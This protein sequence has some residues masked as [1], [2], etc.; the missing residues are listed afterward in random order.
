MSAR[1]HDDDA[2]PSELARCSMQGAGKSIDSGD[3]DDMDDLGLV[4]EFHDIPT[5]SEH[6]EFICYFDVLL[7]VSEQLILSENW[8]EADGQLWEEADHRISIACQGS[9]LVAYG[10][11]ANAGSFEALLSPILPEAWLSL[12]ID[13]CGGQP[14]RDRAQHGGRHYG[15]ANWADPEEADRVTGPAWNGICFRKA[16][17]LRNWPPAGIGQRDE[18]EL[19]G[20]AEADAQSIASASSAPLSS[21]WPSPGGAE[22]ILTAS[23]EL[24]DRLSRPRKK[25]RPK[26][27]AAREVIDELYPA[28]V[29]DQATELNAMLCRRVSQNLKERKPSLAVGDDT[30]L[31]A[32]GRRN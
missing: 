19:A 11:R 15:A 16:D 25:S 14:D 28:G 8:N 21:P 13:I 5:S 12:H 29:P 3:A 32:A 23:S 22:T 26:F 10:F 1:K 17:V 31:R 18:G 2:A 30:I 24:V 4:P 6:G 20:E 7:W 9:R 27:D